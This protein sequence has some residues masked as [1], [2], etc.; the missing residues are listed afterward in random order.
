MRRY[1]ANTNSA[2]VFIVSAADETV[3]PYFHRG[4]LIAHIIPS[5]SSQFRGVIYSNLRLTVEKGTVSLNLEDDQ[6]NLNQFR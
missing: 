6:S 4:V 2:L 3:S 1:A 5:K